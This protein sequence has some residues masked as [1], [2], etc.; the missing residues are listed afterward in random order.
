MTLRK[1]S[2]SGWSA[3]EVREIVLELVHKTHI[4]LVLSLHSWWLQSSY[5]FS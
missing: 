2:N 4:V 1:V 5:Q 3:K